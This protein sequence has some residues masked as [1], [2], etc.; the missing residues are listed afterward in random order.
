MARSEAIEAFLTTGTRPAEWDAWGGD[1]A[2]GEATMRRVLV[3]IVTHRC[4]GAP[5]R[6]RIPTVDPAQVVL[7]RV[8]GM[9][10]GLLHA[11]EARSMA[12]LLR[13]RV[14]VVT[15]ESYESDIAKLSLEDAWTLANVLLEDLGVPPIS[16]DTPQL[17]GLCAAGHA[18]VPPGGL[19]ARTP[20]T[21]VVVHEV[22]HLLHTLTRRD[23]G[24]EGGTGPL[25]PVPPALYESFAYACELWSCGD[26]SG[27]QGGVV[28]EAMH[29]A[30]LM[31][32]RVNRER[33]RAA[34]AAAARGGWAALRDSVIPAQDV[35][36]TA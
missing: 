25:V 11:D 27:V 31:D 5:L 1:A 26:G 17:D 4:E 20:T 29:A 12:R 2:C 21:D 28:Q 16:D 30:H 36:A 34:L 10:D 35:A 9:L 7:D 22:A 19:Q 23:L 33:L 24:L 32:V 6:G 8:R 3:R 18:W 13:E 14:C 15:P